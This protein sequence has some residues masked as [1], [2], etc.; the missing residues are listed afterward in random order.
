MILNGVAP[1]ELIVTAPLV[2]DRVFDTCLGT[3]SR[4]SERGKRKNS[5]CCDSVGCRSPRLPAWGLAQFQA[6]A[7]ISRF[8]TG[9]AALQVF[10]LR[11]C[12]DAQTPL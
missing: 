2:S 1:G 12:H 7:I 5:V 4:R 11:L 3:V 6:H 10:A 9:L 8:Q